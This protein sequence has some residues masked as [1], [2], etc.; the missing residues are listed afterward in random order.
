MPPRSENALSA[1]VDS[2]PQPTIQGKT[3]EVVNLVE[4][5]GLIPKECFIKSLPKSLFY[6][7]RDMG[8]I[9]T[10]Q[11]A[12]ADYVAG[13][14]ML[15]V[16]WWNVT[17]FMMWALFVVGHD[18]GHTTFS[19]YAWINSLCGHLCHAPLLV[20][21]W[22]WA[23]SHNEHHKYH[24]HVEKDMSFPW[25]GK[26]QY[27][28]DCSPLAKFWLKTPFHG[29]TSYFLTYLLAGFYDGSHFN[30]F[31]NLFWSRQERVQAAV[32]LVS[33]LA[34]ALLL[35]VWFEGD[36]G[37]ISVRYIAPLG[38]MNYWLMMV[39]YM[40]H[41]E[42]DTKTFDNSDFHFVTAA[43]ETVDR[44]YGWGIDDAHHNITDG[45][46]THHLFFTKIPH[47]NLKKATESIRPRL[48]SLG[49]YRYH[50][51]PNFWW[52]YAKYNY[53]YGFHTHS[54]AHDHRAKLHYLDSSKKYRGKV[55]A[56]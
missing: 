1:A 44:T 20:P 42:P 14:W 13:S 52:V 35:G 28:E 25:F 51:N 45:H 26:Q 3:K 29:F 54:K 36:L 6:M 21:F 53:K 56:S 24:N 23:K 41:H 49:L 5:R 40:Q 9:L 38:I 22:P 46:V 31:G 12:Y 18:C 15:T 50:Y 32:S 16:V 47:Y 11:W 48:E 34:F 19:N 17:G 2:V 37:A 10:L 8:A 7:L 33:V 55:K 30:P 43:M 4:L 39:T 27:E